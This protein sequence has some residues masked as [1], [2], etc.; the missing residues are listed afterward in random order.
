MLLALGGLPWLGACGSRSTLS[1]DA[2]DRV[3][4][5]GGS[6]GMPD[7]D[8]PCEAGFRRTDAGACEDIDECAESLSD[9]S[10][11]ATCVNELGSSSCQCHP[12]WVGD[13]QSCEPKVQRISVQAFGEDGSFGGKFPAI[14]YDGRYVGF[15][16]RSANLVRG[17]AN[18]EEDVFVRDRLLGTTERV[19]LGT[20]GAESN[21]ASTALAL[22]ADGNVVAFFSDATNLVDGDDNG[23]WDVFVRDRALAT[24]ERASVSSSG[25]GANAPASLPALS[26]DG[27]FVAFTSTANN[28]VVGDTNAFTDVFLR[29]R[30][31]GTT[32]RISV[33]SGG[34]PADAPSQGAVVSGDGRYV[35]FQSD[36]S[37][38]GGGDNGASDLFLRDRTAG[39]TELITAGVFGSAADGPSELGAISSD[40]RY[41]VFSSL[42]TNLVYGDLNEQVDVFLFDRVQGSMERVSV[43]AGE[44]NDYSGSPSLSD[45]GRFVVFSSYAD[46]LVSGDDNLGSDIFVRD[47]HSA[48]TA[49]VSLDAFGVQADSGSYAPVISGN[50]HVIAFSSTASNLVDVDENHDADV[51][52]VIGSGSGF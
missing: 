41:V 52:V 13:G 3:P 7:E 6:P 36:A 46:N 38:L 42:A 34:V 50:G 51:Y 48:T 47:R 4:A 22:S 17:D 14:S 2:G 32:E 21:G 39:T 33:G 27:R 24:T 16:S 11:N 29:D 20:T 28:L 12:G 40:G 18:G 26:G 10:E 25:V 9:C 30:E 31:L 8:E 35:L 44:G 19:S 45:D 15:V 23:G 5:S 43:S 49:R 37:N 1:V